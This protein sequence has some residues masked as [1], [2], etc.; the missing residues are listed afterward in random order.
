[1]SKNLAE[2]AAEENRQAE[3]RTR[4]S[5]LLNGTELSPQQIAEQ[6]K[7]AN[8]QLIYKHAE[9]PAARDRRKQKK[10]DEKKRGIQA[11]PAIT[12]GTAQITFEH[13][14]TP[15]E[16]TPPELLRTE[17]K[18]KEADAER[19]PEPVRI[20]E[21]KHGAFEGLIATGFEL[22]C[23]TA[24]LTKPNPVKYEKLDHALVDFCLAWQIDFHDPRV[25]PTILL[26]AT[27][28]EISLPLVKE[29]RGKMGG[30]KEKPP[31]DTV[32]KVLAPTIPADNSKVN[33]A[34]MERVSQALSS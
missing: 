19:A 14:E 34:D 21:L 25:L 32:E 1:M 18:E 27:V 12:P 15:L 8:V 5:Q 10:R 31:T 4:I 28:G 16:E 26:L 30:P 13:K 33:P 24:K 17:D 3:L 11:K 22:L 6:L 2:E 23:D 7:I 29:A 9:W 20:F